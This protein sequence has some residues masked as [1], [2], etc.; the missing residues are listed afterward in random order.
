MS[1]C[2]DAGLISA[3]GSFDAAA[4]EGLALPASVGSAEAQARKAPEASALPLPGVADR[5]E[6]QGTSHRQLAS[7][8]AAAPQGGSSSAPSPQASEAPLLGRI[9]L[10]LRLAPEAM[11]LLR[12]LADGL[13]SP[14]G[15][16]T[17]D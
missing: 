13:V 15:A 3:E 9:E 10:E 17:A 1:S 7:M 6:G 14:P 2:A 12:R 8:S 11:A 16:H 4:I 5:M